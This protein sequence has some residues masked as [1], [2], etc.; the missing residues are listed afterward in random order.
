LLQGL[1]VGRACESVGLL[2]SGRISANYKR[3]FGEL[4]R[5][6]RSHRARTIEPVGL[7]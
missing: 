1:E 5:Q 6:T 2:H 3:M 7:V 4:P